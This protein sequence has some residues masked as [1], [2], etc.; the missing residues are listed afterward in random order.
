MQKVFKTRQFMAGNSPAVRIPVHMAFPPKTE[1][2]VIREGNRIVVEAQTGSL[3]SVPEIF[4]KIGKK[5]SR[6]RP[7]FIDAERKW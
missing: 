3:E 5:H 6:K 4:H 1:L 7:E 2:L